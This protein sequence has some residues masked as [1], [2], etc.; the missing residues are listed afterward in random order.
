MNATR[1]AVVDYYGLKVK[2]QGGE[3]EPTDKE[4]VEYEQ[5]QKATKEKKLLSGRQMTTAGMPCR[6]ARLRP[7]CLG[8]VDR[9]A[10]TWA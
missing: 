4:R 5:F 3:K 2:G 10:V 7:R 1:E 8:H 6:V 9:A